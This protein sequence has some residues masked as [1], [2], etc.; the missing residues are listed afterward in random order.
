MAKPR[1]WIGALWTWWAVC[2][3]F[4]LLLWSLALTGQNAS[5]VSARQLEMTGHL[6]ELTSA[7]SAMEKLQLALASSL[8]L[9]ADREAL[10]AARHQ[11]EPFCSLYW[12]KPDDSP[13]IRND[14]SAPSWILKLARPRVRS[15]GSPTLVR[16]LPP[17]MEAGRFP[18]GQGEIPADAPASYLLACARRADG[19]LIVSSLNLPYIWDTWLPQRLQSFGLKTALTWRRIPPE[20]LWTDSAPADNRIPSFLG[21]DPYPLD[22]LLLDL[23]NRQ[24][25][26]ENL[27]AHLAALAG[28]LLLMGTFAFSIRLAAR[29]VR[30]ELE[31]TEARSRFTAMVSHELRT[32]IAAIKMYN[33]ILETGLIEDPDK[34]A[35]YQKLIGTEAGR[36]GR[37][38][39]SLLEV[40]A[41]EGGKRIF[42]LQ[43]EKL[44]EIAQEAVD[45]FRRSHPQVQVDMKLE[46][47]SAQCD[48]AAT[49]QIVENL[50]NN[51]LKYGAAP[52]AVAT[53]EL[54]IEVS[55]SGPGIPAEMRKRVFLPYERIASGKPGVGLGLAV[56][57]GFMEGQGGRVEVGERVGGGALFTLVFCPA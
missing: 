44:D 30:R 55:D 35:S 34:L 16:P 21:D 28:G 7:F 56:V 13:V 19:T 5:I 32:P 37:L 1:K 42:R 8:A 26:R 29:G 36:L 47:G 54:S 45:T 33:E 12:V 31:F 9:R 52:I 11:A 43:V 4:L 23:D 22:A 24:I 18:P 17:G 20:E 57:K 38:V 51:A 48:R 6:R 46:G 50:L 15:D 40:G 53:R 39:D 14:S 25:L 3:I 27:R 41:L 2:C 49:L 10:Q